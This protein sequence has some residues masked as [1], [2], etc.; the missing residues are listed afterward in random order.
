MPIAPL[1]SAALS[2]TATLGGLTAMTAS[3][4]ASVRDRRPQLSFV[5]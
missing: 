3:A 2:L 1:V 5:T 4:A